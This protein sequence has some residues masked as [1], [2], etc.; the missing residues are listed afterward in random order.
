MA[1]VIKDVEE[2]V[3]ELPNFL[4][5]ASGILGKSIADI[6]TSTKEFTKGVFG[7]SSGS[8][9]TDFNQKTL[10]S[11]QGNLAKTTPKKTVFTS[12]SL[13]PGM[14]ESSKGTF[15]NI[16]VGDSSLNVVKNRHKL[17]TE[18]SIT[19]AYDKATSS[20]KGGMI[21]GLFTSVNKVVKPVTSAV[22]SVSKTVNGFE[23][24]ARSEYESMCS[25]LNNAFES[26][27]STLASELNDNI[28]FSLIQF[29][30][31]ASQASNVSTTAL[32][33]TLAAI[34]SVGCNI[35]DVQVKA[36]AAKQSL[37][38]NLFKLI[39]T[40]KLDEFINTL[41]NC[42]NYDATSETAATDV[43]ESSVSMDVVTAN[44]I[45]SNL[46]KENR[47]LSKDYVSKAV[48]NTP[49]DPNSIAAL[50]EVLEKS[51]MSGETALKTPTEK[52]TSNQ[53]VGLFSTT[54][55]QQTN[56]NVVKKLTNDTIA[57]YADVLQQ[58]A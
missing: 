37:F 18:S 22:S 7:D 2:I 30:N 55:L 26:N 43:F 47:V 13:A 1:D 16:N 5:K 58:V 34:K 32:N 17:S 42:S 46:K 57:I 44:K 29:G 28:P 53:G 41:F 39:P 6:S 40:L 12:T 45:A 50:E 4:S 52:E 23:K 36:Q 9:D 15:T 48:I 21:G 35:G 3:S 19:N 51:L 49:A 11:V 10:D 33:S 8:T 27:V 38:N 24:Q 25:S 56:T 14:T 54:L 20:K 31:G